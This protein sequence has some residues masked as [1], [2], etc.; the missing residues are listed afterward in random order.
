MKDGYSKAMQLVNELNDN[1][2]QMDSVIYGNLLAICASNNLCEEA[3]VFF[4]KMK[5][6]GYTPNLFHYSSLLNAYSET[7]N[8]VKAE[9][10]IKDMKSSGLVPNKVC[11]SI[12]LL[13]VSAAVLG[14]HQLSILDFI[15]FLEE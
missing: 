8:Y 9:M 12:L 14:C 10:L 13:L 1:G 4:Q 11:L 2:L 7:G 6:E 15:C 5:N 3:E